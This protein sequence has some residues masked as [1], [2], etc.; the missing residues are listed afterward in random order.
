MTCLRRVN[1]GGFA[2]VTA[3]WAAF[4]LALI[5]SFVTK[6]GRTDAHVAHSAIRQAELHAAA[7]GALAIMELRLLSPLGRLA[8]PLDDTPV[9]IT[10]AG[11]QVQVAVQDQAGLIDLN[12]A[13]EETL[14]RL[15]EAAGLNGLNAQVLTDRVMDWRERGTS[16]R[17]N[18]AKAPDYAA[19]GYAYGP[20]EGPFQSVAELK[21][22]VGVSAAIFDRVEPLLT[23]YSQ[24][25]IVEAASA[26]KLVLQAILGETPDSAA[27]QI[28]ARQ[29]ALANPATETR[30][31]LMLAGRS[32]RISTSVLAAGGQKLS[33][34]TVVRP[35][36]YLSPQFWTY[37][38]EEVTNRNLIR[39]DSPVV[40][41]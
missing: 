13:S 24:K 27:V 2:L 9:K 6:A 26:P 25:P 16:K 4:I 36:G 11:Y 10:C 37:L 18:G 28:Q 30:S 20:R 12:F 7:R 17:L 29:E 40:G 38:D 5:A 3:L 19:A 23:V 15:F 39:P 33:M 35:T 8:P 21:L 22:V 1:D 41:R 14:H 32:V 34:A 31:T